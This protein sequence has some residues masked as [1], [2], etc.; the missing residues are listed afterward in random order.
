MDRLKYYL[1]ERL[2]GLIKQGSVS[3]GLGPG[4]SLSGNVAIVLENSRKILQCTSRSLVPSPQ[5]TEH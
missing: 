1:F 3:I 4:H 2:Q 5:L